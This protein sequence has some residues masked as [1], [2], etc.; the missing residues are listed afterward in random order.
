MI[1]LADLTRRFG[2]F[3]A[4]DRVG[5][6]V[7]PGEVFGLIGANGAGKSTV[8]RML[9]TLLPPT[10]GHATVTGFDVV[11]QAAAG[12][13]TAWENLLLSARLYNIPS[14]QVRGAAWNAGP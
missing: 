7:A 12:A 9:T 1:Q 4:V 13:L 5:F 14:G 2:D 6:E 3:T 11:R 8:I 10:G